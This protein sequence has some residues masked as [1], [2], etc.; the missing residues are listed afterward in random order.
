[1]ILAAPQGRAVGA[2]GTRLWVLG[3]GD[4]TAIRDH[5]QCQ[6]LWQSPQHLT[7]LRFLQKVPVLSSP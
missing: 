3:A 1:M 5:L 7:I 4:T 6:G 2:V